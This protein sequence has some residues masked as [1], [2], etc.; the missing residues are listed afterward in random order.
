M[1]WKE[2]RV[3]DERVQFIADV[4]KGD[5]NIKKLCELYQISRT[6]GYKWI[7]RFEQ[8][9]PSGL[10]DLGRRPKICADVTPEPIVKQVLELRYANPT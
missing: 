5:R 2:S 3:V 6:T 10:E 7:E 9:G 4:L 8:A 1:P